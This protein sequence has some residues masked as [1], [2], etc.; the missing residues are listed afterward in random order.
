MKTSFLNNAFM[1]MKLKKAIISVVILFVYD[2][3]ESL[4]QN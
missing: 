2:L 1:K 4:N 3:K